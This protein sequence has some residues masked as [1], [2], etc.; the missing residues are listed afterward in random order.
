[1]RFALSTLLCLSKE[2]ISSPAGIGGALK[3]SIDPRVRPGLR[4]ALILPFPLE[5]LPVF[6]HRISFILCFKSSIN[7]S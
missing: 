6:G 7:A 4:G 5:I 3:V 1:M 2:W